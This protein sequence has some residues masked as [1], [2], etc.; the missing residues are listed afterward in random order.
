LPGDGVPVRLLVTAPHRDA[1]TSLPDQ[2][3]GVVYARHIA[4]T[5]EVRVLSALHKF[6]VQV[7][8]DNAEGCFHSQCFSVRFDVDGKVTTDEIAKPWQYE[9]LTRFPVKIEDGNVLVL[10]RHD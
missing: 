5:D 4:A 8:Y 10:L 6:G 9:D 1:W 3:V 2:F 7:T